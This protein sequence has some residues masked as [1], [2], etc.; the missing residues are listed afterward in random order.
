MT[1]TELLGQKI[2]GCR[3]YAGSLCLFAYHRLEDLE[4]EPSKYHPYT[5][6]GSGCARQDMHEL[7]SFTKPW[8]GDTIRK[9]HKASYRRKKRK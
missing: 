9:I 3:S 7:C 1:L 8:S 5:K 6:L 2:V 4:K